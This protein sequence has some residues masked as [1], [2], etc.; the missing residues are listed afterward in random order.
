MDSDHK[1]TDMVKGFQIS[2]FVVWRWSLFATR[3]VYFMR[4]PITNL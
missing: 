1:F 2:S 4:R 3:T